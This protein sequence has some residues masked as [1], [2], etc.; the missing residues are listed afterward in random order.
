MVTSDRNGREESVQ[1]CQGLGGVIACVIDI[2]AKTKAYWFGLK[3]DQKG[4]IAQIY[5]PKPPKTTQYA[6]GAP[7]P[8]A[9]RGHIGFFRRLTL[10]F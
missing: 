3:H 6:S 1:F 4:L 9:G 2:E 10:G 7:P 8:P 5:L